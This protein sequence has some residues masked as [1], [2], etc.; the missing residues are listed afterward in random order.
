MRKNEKKLIF[1]LGPDGPI[2]QF[3][4]VVQYSVGSLK[5]PS[6][7]SNNL[8][9]LDQVKKSCELSEA[10]AV[11]DFKADTQT[12]GSTTSKPCGQTLPLNSCTCCQPRY[13][14]RYKGALISRR[15]RSLSIAVLI[16]PQ[17]FCPKNG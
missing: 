15:R 5:I 7:G 2:L 14:Y 12:F 4:L 11:N 16:T 13:R 10:L 9:F 1:S 6:D 8:I 3:F 17:S